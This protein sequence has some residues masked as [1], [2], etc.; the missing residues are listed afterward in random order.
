MS[1]CLT[2][3]RKDKPPEDKEVQ[4]KNI[5]GPGWTPEVRSRVKRLTE[6]LLEELEQ[7]EREAQKPEGECEKKPEP[8]DRKPNGREA[9][10][11]VTSRDVRP[12]LAAV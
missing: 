12:N 5:R 2:R 8:I 10:S 11:T 9:Y 6:W 3:T 7:K 4:V 1:L